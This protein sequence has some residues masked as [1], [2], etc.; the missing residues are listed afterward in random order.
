MNL[1]EISSS[2]FSVCSDFEAHK[3]REIIERKWG[4]FLRKPKLKM[5]LYLFFEW[6]ENEEWT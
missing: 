6:K 3:K 1:E 5:V 2:P 4:A